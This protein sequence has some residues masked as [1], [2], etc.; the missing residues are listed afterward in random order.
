M[1][2]KEG[3]ETKQN[4][5][6]GK[7]KSFIIDNKDKYIKGIIF[8][9]FINIL[10][11]VTPRLTGD[12]VDHIKN[13]TVGQAGLGGYAIIIVIV[14][15][16]IFI[17]SYLSRLQIMGASTLFEYGIRNDMFK[18]LQTLCMNYF[19]KHSV[20]SI[21][22]LSVND[23]NAIRM[24]MGRG[25]NMVFNTLFLLIFS[26]I[27]LIKTIDLKLTLMVFIPYPILIFVMVKFGTVI[28]NRFRRVQESFSDLTAKVQENISGIRVIKAFS[29]EEEEI[30]NFEQLNKNNY[31]RNMELVRIWGLFF[32]LIGLIGSA[33]YL[34]I[35]YYGGN[36]V[37]E[38]TITIG[39][40][41]A[42][43]SYIGIITRP[44][45]FI[46][47]IINF[48]QRG[49]AS[50]ERI[51][52]LFMAKSN[53]TDENN[54]DKNYDNYRFKG[55][56]EFK[57]LTITYDGG[58]NPV[59]KNISFKVNPGETVAIMGK[60]GS[61]KS[62]LASLLLRLYNPDGK[63]QIFIDGKEITSI[64]VK[65]VRD[66]IGYAP[67][68]N[69]LFSAS[70]ADN[71]AFSEKEYDT[72]EIE[73]AAKISRVY[74]QIE[75]FP[76]RFDTLLGERGVNLSGGQKQRISIARAL[77]KDPPI[78]I[79]DDCL[80]AVDTKTEELIL[81]ELKEVMKERTCIVIAHRVSMIKDADKIIVLDK[82]EII[83]QG[84]HDE[85]AKN[86]G[87]YYKMHQ[88]QLLEQKVVNM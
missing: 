20:G 57:N 33:S 83:E 22:A 39:D 35:L 70:I 34:I 7:I 58:S 65:V 40:F 21:M 47:T 62:T 18:H 76:E 29:Q 84:N 46:G 88:R 50:A 36:M 32:P 55:L 10:Q 82:G 38:N 6:L 44:I 74:E 67:Q 16:L 41:V 86:K 59:L 1:A 27:I 87:Y 13:K 73:K 8:L 17:L 77:I 5:K 53:I 81:R 37:I 30:D 9:F 71:I 45:A 48:I 28:S 51:E 60:V 56:I 11:L 63:G 72:S 80:S 64:P 31:K 24:A 79:L 49:K 19:N 69:F 75:E 52:S 3:K 43:N 85:L 25:I 15:L 14:A 66:N 78:L 2:R 23:V 4:I 61:G 12:V 26:L 42:F 54:N 68:D